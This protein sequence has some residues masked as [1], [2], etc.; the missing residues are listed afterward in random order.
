MGR[1]QWEPTLL[2]LSPQLFLEGIQLSCSIPALAVLPQTQE[3]TFL[4]QFSW[5]ALGFPRFSARF[6]LSGLSSLCWS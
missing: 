1:H 4:Q 5:K 2:T 3:M 6:S